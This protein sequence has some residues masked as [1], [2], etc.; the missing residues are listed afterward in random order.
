VLNASVRSWGCRSAE[1]ETK[2]SAPAYLRRRRTTVEYAECRRRLGFDERGD[3]HK[4]QT[5]PTKRRRWV[6]AASDGMRFACRQV[7][8]SK[9]LEVWAR[10]NDQIGEGSCGFVA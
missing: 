5:T 1:V 6:N 9:G 4:C 8:L 10:S 2:L 3:S 7:E